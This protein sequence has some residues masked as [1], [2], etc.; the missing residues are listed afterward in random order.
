VLI[1][2]IS[3]IALVRNACLSIS[4]TFKSE[5]GRVTQQ[6]MQNTFDPSKAVVI[7][8]SAKDSESEA[9]FKNSANGMESYFLS[10]LKIAQSNILKLSSDNTAMFS[11]VIQKMENFLKKHT[12]ATEIF[13]Y[14]VGHGTTVDGRYVLFIPST[15]SNR[16]RVTGFFFDFFIDVFKDVGGVRLYI[17]LDACFLGKATNVLPR[18]AQGTSLFYSSSDEKS[19]NSRGRDEYTMFTGELLQVLKEGKVLKEGE[20]SS[21]LLLSFY[22]LKKLV[23]ESIKSTYADDEAVIPGIHHVGDTD[24]ND[25]GIFPN[26][27]YINPGLEKM[28]EKE[29]KWHIITS[30]KGGVGKTLLSLFLV[31]HYVHDGTMPLVIDLNGV[32]TDLKR[33]ISERDDL[34]QDGREPP[35]LAIPVGDSTLVIVR[36][37]GRFPYLLGWI[38]NSYQMYTPDTFIKFLSSLRNALPSEVEKTFEVG[39]KTVI[40]DTNYHFCNILPKEDSDYSSFSY[41]KTDRFFIWFIW[42]Y[43]QIYNCYQQRLPQEGFYEQTHFNADVNIM[44]RTAGTFERIV[45]ANAK[46]TPFVHVIN[47]MSL[48]E[49]SPIQEL[50]KVL[51][52]INVRQVPELQR[53]AELES[54]SNNLPFKDLV[55]KMV[56]AQTRAGAKQEFSDMLKQVDFPT[57]PKNLFTFY[58]F[59]GDIAKQGVQDIREIE[60]LEVYKTFKKFFSIL[61]KKSN[62]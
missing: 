10:E 28:A 17:I 4:Q 6:N 16:L 46:G 35:H 2:E 14:Y 30:G 1:C 33:L 51:K 49:S 21:P 8:F 37:S 23:T 3:L 61:L 32:N 54:N 26:K 36:V 29:I 18:T 55:D 62:E 60:D 48:T 22:E 42:V 52:G 59:E 27:Q 5:Y 45:N 56:Q 40:I 15:D 19:S 58:T 44:L 39:I 25:I 34:F 12:D 20:R 50:L 11:Q 31:T 47:P 24:I 57:R 13:V 41:W 53:L 9:P 7:I 43:R 38:T